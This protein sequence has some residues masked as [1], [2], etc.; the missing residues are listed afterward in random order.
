MFPWSAVSMMMVRWDI[1][2]EVLGKGAAHHRGNKRRLP[3]NST[4][5]SSHHASSKGKA[6][7]LK[8]K[9][10]AKQATKNFA[11]TKHLVLQRSTSMFLIVL[12]T[13][14]KCMHP[15]RIANQ[16][17]DYWLKNRML[18]FVVERAA[19]AAITRI[20]A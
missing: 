16:S 12:C 18:D 3:R 4:K 19:A 6:S 8:G 10:K 9:R 14:K 15:A 1:A 7:C 17:I 2:L 5:A 13:T 11:G 20:T